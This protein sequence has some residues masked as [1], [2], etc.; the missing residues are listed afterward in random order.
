MALP[1]LEDRAD[2]LERLADL[3]EAQDDADD[4]AAWR[5]RAEAERGKLL[6]PSRPMSMASAIP[7][8]ITRKLTRNEPCWC[9]SGLKYQRCHLDADGS[10][11][12]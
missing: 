4:A 10:R 12:R 11:P 3:R 6:R 7:A 8:R 1:A 9:G 2:V 5:L